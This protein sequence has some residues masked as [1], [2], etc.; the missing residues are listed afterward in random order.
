MDI[1]EHE[2]GKYSSVFVARLF[3]CVD[4]ALGVVGDKVRGGANG[5]LPDWPVGVV[6]QVDR[7]DTNTQLTLQDMKEITYS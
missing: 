5:D 4:L 6:R 3:V 2:H 1:Y 7:E